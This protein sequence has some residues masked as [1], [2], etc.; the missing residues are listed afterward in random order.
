MLTFS[1]FLLGFKEKG[2]LAVGL[3]TAKLSTITPTINQ[4]LACILIKAC[5]GALPKINCHKGLDLCWSSQWH[6]EINSMAFQGILWL[7]MPVLGFVMAEP[8]AQRAQTAPH[9]RN[10]AQSIHKA[11]QST[12]RIRQ[13]L[14]HTRFSSRS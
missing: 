2:R 3:C 14:S 6:Q 11:P 4:A 8:L 10:T 1:V 7:L 12:S 5:V 9:T 13:A